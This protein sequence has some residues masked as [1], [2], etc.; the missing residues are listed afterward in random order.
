LGPSQ[1]EG[2]SE[3]GGLSE[4]GGHPEL[5][6]S[7]LVGLSEVAGSSEVAGPSKVVGPSEVVAELLDVERFIKL[8]RS[9]QKI[10]FPHILNT[11]DWSST[12][13]FHGEHIFAETIANLAF[14][15]LS[16]DVD[17]DS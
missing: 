5:G 2:P 15:S 14:H 13:V 12:K 8:G 16:T 7:E 10:F 9:F 1:V 4:V 3:V 11:G 17:I 6:S